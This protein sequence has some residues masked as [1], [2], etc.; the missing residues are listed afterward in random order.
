MT[1][2]TEGTQALANRQHLSPERQNNCRQLEQPSILITPENQAPNP[3]ISENKHINIKIAKIE[4]PPLTYHN[5]PSSTRKIRPIRYTLTTNKMDP[6]KNIYQ[7]SF[8]G[9]E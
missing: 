2:K 4:S 7:R 9:L 6:L 8:R 3:L 1:E 5:I